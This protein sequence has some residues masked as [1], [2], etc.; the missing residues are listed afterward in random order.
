[1]KVFHEGI[2][3]LGVKITRVNEYKIKLSQPDYE[4]EIL[5]MYLDPEAKPSK[6]PMKDVE[7]GSSETNEFAPIQDVIGKLRFLVDRTRPDLLF[8]LALLSKYAKSPNA[9]VMQELNRLLR[10]LKYTQGSGILI[11]SEESS[12]TH[13]F[14]LSDASFVQEGDCKSAL[15]YMIYLSRDSAPVYCRSM[16]ATTVSLSSTQSEVDALVE[17]TKETIWF[18]GFLTSI[19]VEVRS[20]T[21]LFTD[22]MPLVTLSGEGNH[23]KRSK[24]FV[25]KVSFIKEQVEFGVVA[26]E[27]VRGKGNESDL[28]TKPLVGHL[29]KEHT[30][31]T[32]G[33]QA[34]C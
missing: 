32:L 25:T 11:G 26:V 15:G 33:Y 3:Y 27:H 2:T 21:R 4:Q 19:G 12:E 16:R 6:Y 34:I 28:L 17:L 23:L 18:Q 22:N 9:N 10:F 31:M 5:N 13:L 29:L 1:V 30:N 7:L 24:H 14:G 20:P 8:P